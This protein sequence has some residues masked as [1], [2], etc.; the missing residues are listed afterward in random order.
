VS[1]EM[2]ALLLFML[3]SSPSEDIQIHKSG[4]EITI[5]VDGQETKM[6]QPVIG[7]AAVYDPASDSENSEP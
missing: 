6:I 7:E 3:F 1:G 4:I 5:T 2:M